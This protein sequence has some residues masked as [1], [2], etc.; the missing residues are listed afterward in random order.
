MKCT[1]CEN[2]RQ[3]IIMNYKWA[4]ATATTTTTT[5]TTEVI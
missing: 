1:M 5:T 2:D 3:T 4:T